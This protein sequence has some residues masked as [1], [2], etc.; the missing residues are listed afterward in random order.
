MNNVKSL[1]INDPESAALGNKLDILII[2]L[3]TQSNEFR[4]ADTDSCG[5]V[6]TLEMASICK[7]ILNF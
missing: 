6:A 7:K 2:T 4:N 1:S 5:S 3:L